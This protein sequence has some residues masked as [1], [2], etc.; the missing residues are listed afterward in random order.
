M[1]HPKTTTAGIFLLVGSLA[2]F[3]ARWYLSGTPSGDE[4]V[5]MIT[6]VNAGIAAILSADG[7][8]Q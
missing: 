4:W 6:G 8:K 5:M 7:G 3:A 2:T 1:K